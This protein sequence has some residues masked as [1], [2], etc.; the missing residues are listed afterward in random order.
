M[1]GKASQAA[2]VFLMYITVVGAG[3]VGLSLA[4]LLAK[5]NRVTIVE[6]NHER[7][8]LINNGISPIRDACLEEHLKALYA[9]GRSPKAHTS[10]D[11]IYEQSDLV[12]VATPTDYDPA[13]N[14]FNTSAVESVVEAVN[15][16]N[17][18][19]LIIVK[20][21]IPVGFTARYRG[22]NIA[23]CPEFLREGHAL[24]DNLYPSRI[25][26]GFTENT[27]K[28]KAEQF[29]GAL[30]QASLKENVMVLR[31]QSTEAEAVKLFTNT[32]LALRV[33]Y[34]NELDTYA[35]SN[36]LSTKDI[37][38]G[39]C[40]DPRIGDGYNNPSFGYG[41]YC[42]PKDTKQL[43]ANYQDVP[44]NLIAAIVASNQT[45][46]FYVASTLRL[47]TMPDETVGIYRLTM[48]SGSDNF[49]SSAIFDIIDNLRR[50]VLIYEPTLDAD[51]YDGYE[52][53]HDLEKFKQRCKVI[54]ANRMSDKLKDVEEKV[55]TRDIFRRD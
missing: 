34:F 24:E 45:R 10:P 4:V 20:S 28:D 50:P 40:A 51:E 6:I 26:L 37:I 42:L 17:P 21:N 1:K 19:A 48:K 35:M 2:H 31:M 54:V 5:H 11:G 7:V 25:I 16:V 38:E 14:Y 9:D 8:D 27:D 22:Y 33:S 13:R 49:R 3:Y 53:E 12:I 23:F 43:L 32:Y 46:K 52:V 41:G 15:A 55:F 36:G 29:I 30:L 47:M 39:V 18:N 44:E